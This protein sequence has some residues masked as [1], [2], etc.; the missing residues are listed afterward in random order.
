MAEDLTSYKWQYRYCSSSLNDA[1]Q[2]TDILHDFYLPAL[3]R[4]TRYDRVAGYFRS[5]SLAAASQGY[6]A[7][8]NH[9]G[10]MRL[11]VG[12]DLQIQD[13]EAILEGNHQRLSD[14][15]M[16]E[17]EGAENWPDD[18]QNGVALLGKMVASGQL[19]VRVAFRVN[20]KTGKPISVDSIEDGYV[21]EKWFIMADNDDN[22][23]YG[24]GSM[25]ESRTALVLNA[26][27]I[28]I[29]CDWKGEESK[30]RVEGAEEDF[31]ALWENRNPHM[32]V[33]EIPEAVKKRLIHMKNLRNQ[34]TEIDGTVVQAK[35]EP[36][37]EELLKFAV[38]K[39]APKMPGG[40]YIGMYSAPVE[41]W[42]HQEIVSRRLVESWPYSYMM[43]DEVGLGK[44]I[45]GALA[46]RSL[47]LSGRVKRVLIIPP[48]NLTGQWH[49]ELAQ[50]AMLPFSLSKPKPGS[51]GKVVHTKIY[52]FA[53]E[54]AVD[55]DL[56]GPDLNIVSTGLVSRKERF[57]QLKRAEP[58]DII[59]VDESHYARRQ[60]PR[61]G[62]DGRAK[63]GNLYTSM[64]YGLRLKAKS[65]WMATAT[66]M[67]IDPI[68]A[69]DL[70]R[71]T[72]R[73]GEFQEDPTVSMEYFKMLGNIVNG[74]KLNFQQWQILGQSFAQI[75]ALD[76]YLWNNLQQTAVTGKNRKVLK[77]LPVQEP[78]KA[79]IHQ[80]IQPLFA[81]SP[82]SRVMMRHTRA[83]LEIYRENGELTS[84]LARRHVRPVCAVKFTPQEE[85]FY[86]ML[87]AYCNELGRQ[88][89]KYN[90]QTRQVMV[91]LLNFLQLRFASSFYAI[92]MTLY[93]RLMRVENTLKVGARTFDSQEE[94][95]EALNEMCDVDADYDEGDLSDIT[96]DALL[97]DRSKVDLE[98]EKTELTKMLAY[99][100]GITDTPSK[101]Q[102][103]LEELS[104]RQVGNRMR[105]TVLFTRFYDTLTSIR[106]FL[107][108]RDSDMRVGIYA[109]GVSRYYDPGKG[110]DVNTTHD[111][112]KRMF[113]NGDIDLLLCTD[114]AA[115]GLNLQTADLLINFDL[116]WNPMK[117]EQRIGRIDRIG[118]KYSDIEVMNMCYLGSTE[119]IVYG[120]LLSRL[121]TASLVVGSQQISMLPVEP[122]EFRQLHDGEI[123]LDE[124]EKRSVSRLKQQREANAS[125]EMSAEDMYQMYSRM[126]AQ[127]R[128]QQYP[129]DIGQLWDTLV[130]S[131]YLKSCGAV[132][133]DN[134][135]WY[136]P[137][138]EEL[139]EISGTIDRSIVSD[140]LEF[141]TWGNHNIDSLLS[142]MSEKLEKTDEHIQR[143]AVSICGF[144]TVG[145]AVSTKDGP[146][147][148]TSFEQAQSIKVDLGSSLT[149]DNIQSCTNELQSMAAVDVAQIATAEDA[150]KRNGEV[151]VLHR[152]LVTC[153][154][155][156][157]L[158]EMESQGCDKFSDA[159]KTLENDTKSI[160][161]AVLPYLVFEGKAALLLFPISQNSGEI[162]VMVRGVLFDCAI[163]MAKREAAGIKAKNSD[164]KTADVIRR[165]EHRQGA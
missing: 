92:Q 135:T 68:E 66:P 11:I 120:R 15:L 147:L 45:E 153:S 150:E 90:P 19:E 105:Q 157:L 94:M 93:R 10:Q 160:H 131:N 33:M 2:P 88:I 72:N 48:A 136:L 30:E 61:E 57:E 128:A 155:I 80:L 54:E 114:A 76:P 35:V 5:S 115:E 7:F 46:I 17:L 139:P 111:E 87:E 116:G 145:Y 127:M 89:R 58:C 74:K 119:Q 91:F 42:P 109:G 44:T 71:L 164:K 50:K 32:C 107:S 21:H 22:R 100:R 129:A 158:R 85:T 163:A 137:R 60:N 151:S 38:L 25:N 126:S 67:Q 24:S 62:A 165:L 86:N 81:A 98:W 34:P 124:L 148:V 9:S 102:A 4:A 106:S 16:N 132:L 8:L 134:E 123:T 156:A 138:N 99:L 108:V 159:I 149:A 47:V 53:D 13:V 113:L 117:I 69:Y 101:M 59:L 79:D 63:Y 49:R 43:C 28:D 3:S 56:Y 83:L 51:T 133:H 36:S 118:Q 18:V 75:E 140:D 70:F 26:E 122:D 78:K 64:Q 40:V 6:S 41:P 152:Q 31:L 130:S 1:G 144:E 55:S 125:M 162:Q 161:Y 39:D 104:K 73:V 29:H 97:K 65:L 121:A 82:L 27:N 110:T 23:L 141:L 12:A 112:I 20:A 77:N 52:P 103:L 95:D 154:S 143:I 146:V 96:L 37:P 142:T 84:N 14:S